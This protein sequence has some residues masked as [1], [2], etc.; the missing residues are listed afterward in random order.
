MFVRDRQRAT[1]ER[2]SVRKDGG[3]ACGGRESVEAA[4]SADGR[5]VAFQSDATNLV[6]RDRNGDEDIFIRVPVR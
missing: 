5:V 4:I 1:T 6:P 3:L 2:V